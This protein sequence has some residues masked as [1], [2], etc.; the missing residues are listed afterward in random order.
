MRLSD[1]TGEGGACGSGGLEIA[2]LAAD[3]RKVRP[4]CLFA[5]MSDDVARRD[6]F[7]ADAARRGA[8]AVMAAPDARAAARGAGLPLVAA[9]EPR[10][11]Y[12]H[13]AARFHAAQPR[14]VVAVTGT[15]GKTSV[16][17]FARQIWR[18]LGHRAA[19]LGTL[20]LDA[21]DAGGAGFGACGPQLTTPDAGDLHRLLA[22]LSRAGVDRLA[23]EASS[24]GLAQHRLDGV[25]LSAAAFTTF[26]R[27][28]L[29]YHGT[30]EAY[31]AAKARLFAELLPS[32][33]TAVLNRGA[34]RFAELLDICRGR[35]RR[36]VTCGAGGDIRLADRDGPTLFFDVF[37]AR[38]SAPTS[39][40]GGFQ[41][42]NLL[43]A[44]ALVTACGA[45]PARA[46]EA[47]AAVEAAPGRMQR[48]AVRDGA[49]I[50]VD[51]AHTPDA[52][53]AALAALRPRVRGGLA[54]VFGCGGD[55]DR[56]KRPQMGAAAARLAD[57]IV[58]TDDNPRSEDAAAIR[59]EARAGCPSAEEIGD[60]EDAIAA[61]ID[62]LKPGDVLL[63]AGK[64]HETGQ[65]V[66]DTTLPFDDAAVARRIVG[67]AAS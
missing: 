51:Y 11:R 18:A 25:R 6:A 48:V 28:H 13:I 47:T 29:D 55:R 15:N 43:C 63:I 31:F 26:G 67:E 32:G 30:E 12:A 16:A 53:R 44:L 37:G 21:G 57:R 35:G 50:Y 3:S 46:A 4:G 19:S 23:L 34:A 9:R 14:T 2:G 5:A 22:E 56:G 36:T 54:V 33:A 38:Y 65:I 39:L 58:I 66:G 45:D 41:I 24:H 52:L 8:V 10:R 62:G 59:A 42:D 20:G 27:D 49:E 61:A 64:G 40:V 17:V 7:I 60:R 1:L